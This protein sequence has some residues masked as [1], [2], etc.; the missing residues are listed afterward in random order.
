MSV[1]VTHSSPRPVPFGVAQGSVLGPILFLLYYYI[2]DITDHIQSTICLF[3]D[4]SM[5]YRDI[6]NTCDHALLQQ[7][8]C[9][10]VE[11]WQLNFNITK[12][13]HLG[14]RN[15]VVPFSWNHRLCQG[16][17]RPAVFGGLYE[18]KGDEYNNV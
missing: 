6:K 12:C 8:L 5:V 3:A 18:D 7:D 14:I 2:N 10:W 1:K 17:F 15:K 9:E 16:R 11:I 4:E 13:Y